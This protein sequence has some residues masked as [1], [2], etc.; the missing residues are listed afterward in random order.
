VD[1]FLAGGRVDSGSSSQTVAS[2]SAAIA[3]RLCE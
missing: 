1:D 3:R 2:S